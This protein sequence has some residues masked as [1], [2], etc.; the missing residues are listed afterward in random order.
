ME[1]D[2]ICLN[3]SHPLNPNSVLSGKMERGWNGT[4][5]S[6][7]I[8]SALIRRIRSISIP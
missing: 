5:G 2:L 8:R 3:Q 6:E 1:A 7:Q 4:A